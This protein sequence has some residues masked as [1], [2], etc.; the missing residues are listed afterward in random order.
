MS[1]T[2]TEK[3]TL[4]VITDRANPNQISDALA[5][6]QLARMLDPVKITITGLVAVAAVDITTLLKG[7]AGVV[8]NQGLANLDANEALPAILSPSTLR[9]SAV[10]TAAL[11]ARLVT[12]A[13]GTASATLA[14]I[15][16]DGKTLTFEGTI[17][18][19]VLEYI[20]RSAT[21][22]GTLFAPLP[23]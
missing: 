17:T 18:G 13:G 23:A 16:D 8:I 15:S 1:V 21:A 6:I 11:G 4:A 2:V 12:D 3:Q 10:G 14:L 19:F 20:P 5:K 9:V 7:A 22:F